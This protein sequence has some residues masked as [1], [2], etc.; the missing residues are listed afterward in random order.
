MDIA[1]KVRET[2]FKALHD[3]MEAVL[4]EAIDAAPVKTGTLRRSGTIT[5]SRSR[6]S[7]FI[8]FNT[9]YAAIVHDGSEPHEILPVKKKAL[10][11]KGAAHPVKRVLHPGTKPNPFLTRTVEKR[12]DNVGGY[13]QDEVIKTIDKWL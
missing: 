5:D 6:Q 10:Y 2:A 4:T 1:G 8:S 11:W 12:L 9:P 7:V 3:S 13:I